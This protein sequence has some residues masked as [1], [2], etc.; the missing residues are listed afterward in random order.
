[1]L[2][3]DL[4]IDRPTPVLSQKY[5]L[6]SEKIDELKSRIVKSLDFLWQSK[7]VQSLFREIKQLEKSLNTNQ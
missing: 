7:E 4:I 5:N 1:M 2:I 6:P 3:T